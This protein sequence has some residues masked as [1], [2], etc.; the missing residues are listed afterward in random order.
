VN[1]RN[2]TAIDVLG[3]EMPL[4]DCTLLCARA[5][6]MDYGDPE[7][8]F[9]PDDEGTLV[10]VSDMTYRDEDGNSVDFDAIDWD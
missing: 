3:Q 2:L 6:S 9:L 10:R 4:E 8:L 5:G 1:Y 7:A